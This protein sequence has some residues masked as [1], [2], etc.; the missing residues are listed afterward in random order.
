[1]PPAPTFLDSINRMFNRAAA[2]MDLPPGLAEQIRECNNVYQVRGL[3]EG[4]T[5]VSCEV[6]PT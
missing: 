2:C 3:N 4:A 6:R 1:M 5:R